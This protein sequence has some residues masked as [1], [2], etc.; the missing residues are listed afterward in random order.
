VVGDVASFTSQ[1]QGQLLFDLAV[2]AAGE[3]LLAGRFNQPLELGCG[4]IR[5]SGASDVFVASFSSSLAARWSARGSDPADQEI[6]RAR[7]GPDGGFWVGGQTHGPF[8][9]GGR[10]LGRMNLPASFF[11]AFPP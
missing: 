2:N 6:V 5:A 7:I 3:S 4:S 1:N 9:F 10:T 8:D 11:A